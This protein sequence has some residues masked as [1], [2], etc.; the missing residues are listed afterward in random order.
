MA[1]SQTKKKR[2][3]KEARE[4]KETLATLDNLGFHPKQEKGKTAVD[5]IDDIENALTLDEEGV[6]NL[7]LVNK[8]A[9][10]RNHYTIDDKVLAII[11]MNAFQ[12]DKGGKM[13]PKYDYVARL[14]GYPRNSI[15]HW[16]H[17]RKELQKQ[18]SLVLNKGF[19]VIQVRLMSSLMKMTETMS[20]IDFNEMLGKGSSA[21]MKNFILMM[22]STISNLRLMSNLSTKNV[23]HHHKGGVEMIVPED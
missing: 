12:S 23:A 2:L 20:T 16:W 11:F 9:G 10:G 19:E 6:E 14:F 4:A 15:K 18:Q 8:G 17:Q 3:L 1:D 7:G 5:V 21:D 13:T 22:N